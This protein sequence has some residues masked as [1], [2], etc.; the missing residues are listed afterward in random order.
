MDDSTLRSRLAGHATTLL[1]LSQA[2]AAH[3]VGGRWEGPARRACETQ[4]VDLEQK[5]FATAR[6]LN[7]VASDAGVHNLRATFR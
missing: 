5:L 4:V 7:G 1:Q 3:S 6:K 2:L